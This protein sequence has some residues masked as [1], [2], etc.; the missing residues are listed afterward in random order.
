MSPGGPRL[1][2]IHFDIKPEPLNQIMNLDWIVLHLI[3]TWAAATSKPLV[4]NH[5]KEGGP[6]YY[7]VIY[8]EN[9]NK[10]L[11]FFKKK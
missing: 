11:P 2:T 3:F 6:E 7:I 9:V 1:A 4:N 8:F 10:Q 5:V